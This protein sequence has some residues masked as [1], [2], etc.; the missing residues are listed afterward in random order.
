MVRHARDATD[1]QARRAGILEAAR[2]LF[3]D[4]PQKL[5]SASRIA[6]AAG[7]AKGTLYLYF[8]TKEEIFLALL[9]EERDQVLSLVHRFFGAGDVPLSEQVERFLDGY[10]DHLRAHPQMLQLESQGH[11]VL[12]RNMDLERLTAFK[13]ESIASLTSAGSLIDRTLALAPGQG[14]R[15]LIHTY[16]LSLGLWQSLDLPQSCLQV[17]AGPEMA[18]FRLDF[19]VELR[20]ALARYWRLA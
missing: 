8:L 1:K 9:N 7:L 18:T 19:H 17:L 6:D 2:R 15:L 3:L 14:T 11:S 5:P 16:A 13:L 4:E 12:E 20:D 10:L